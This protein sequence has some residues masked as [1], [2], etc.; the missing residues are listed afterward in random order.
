MK[1]SKFPEVQKASLLKYASD[2]M[3]VAE[4][5]GKTGSVGRRISIGRKSTTSA[6]DRD[7]AAKAARR[8]EREAAQR[9]LWTCHLTNETA[10]YLESKT[11]RP[12]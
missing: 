7:A 5:C 9:S 11:V 12:V 1:A 4:T 2:G 10:R 6:A 8:R 3:P